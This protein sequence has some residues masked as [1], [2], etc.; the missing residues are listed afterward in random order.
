MS[1]IRWAVSPLFSSSL[2][3]LSFLLQTI[4]FLNGTQTFLDRA[5]P[6]LFP[7]VILKS[8]VFSWLRINV[9]MHVGDK[10]K[11]R[12]TPNP[13]KHCGAHVVFPRKDLREAELKMADVGC[14]SLHPFGRCWD[15]VE[16]R[17]WINSICLYILVRFTFCLLYGWQTW[18]CF[19][20]AS[21]FFLPGAN[22][23]NILIIHVTLFKTFIFFLFSRHT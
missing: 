19:I 8:S 21:S 22:G 7:E 18:D 10:K 4:Y 9:Q 15:T 12:I 20:T 14:V 6:S 17:T 5:A 1:W 16:Q 11:N 3:F 2:I 13:S 23:L